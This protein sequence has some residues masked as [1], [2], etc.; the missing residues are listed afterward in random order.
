[1]SNEKLAFQ[2][3]YSEAKNNVQQALT[4]I[5][6]IELADEQGMEHLKNIKARLQDISEKFGEDIKFLENNS[7]WDKFTIAFFGETGAGK[8]TILEALRIVFNEKER[9]EQIKNGKAIAED[10]EKSFAENSNS[11][12]KALGESAKKFEHETRDLKGQIQGFTET[13]MDY[14]KEKN[15]FIEAQK[16][17]NQTIEN[18]KK[19]YFFYI[20][21]A[22]ISAISGAILMKFLG[23]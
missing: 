7:E 4:D 10:L 3:L 14:N 9:Q 11:L 16:V 6:S 13:V 19:V 22:L 1:M 20:A 12:I 15:N 5:S 17:C 18:Y 23:N 8:S 2:G 21:I